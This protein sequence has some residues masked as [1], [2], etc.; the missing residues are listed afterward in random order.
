[1]LYI[2]W[3][4]RRKFFKRSLIAAPIAIAGLA[5]YG[6][7]LERHDLEIV[8]V[9][10]SLGLPSPITVGIL[11]DIHFDPL[12]ETDYLQSVIATMNESSPDLLLF[13]GDFL[14]QSTERLD[15]LAQILLSATA[16]RGVYAVLG[17]HDHWSGADNVTKSLASIG[18]T[19][20]R[21]QS[22]RLPQIDNWYLSG[23]ESFWGGKPNTKS[24]EATPND[25]KHILLVHEPDPFDSLD[26]QRIALQISGHTHGGQ[27]RLP[28]YGALQLPSWGR[29]YELGLYRKKDRLLYVNRGIGTVDQHYRINCR[30]EL[31]LLNL[32]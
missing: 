2:E 21:N 24:I 22:L 9:D 16:P 19:V 20:L 31:T 18:I 13:T 4:N 1:M 25:S 14:S 6:R 12:Y 8:F 27:I 5:G 30:P 32:T 23:L 10:I 17:N 3:M 26:D 15:E 11:G 7:Y 28:F 29:R